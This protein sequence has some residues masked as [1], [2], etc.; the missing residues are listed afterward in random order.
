MSFRSIFNASHNSVNN[1]PVSE[2]AT[3]VAI[4]DGG[5][6]DNF[7]NELFAYGFSVDCFQRYAYNESST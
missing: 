2:L 1:F 6:N 4:H 7:L 3:S 5:P